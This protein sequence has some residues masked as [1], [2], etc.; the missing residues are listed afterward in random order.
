MEDILFLILQFLV[1]LIFEFICNLPW[2]FF[3]Y[4]TD[5]QKFSYWE[6]GWIT[7]GLGGVAGVVSLYFLPNAFVHVPFWRT[8]NAGLCPLSTGLISYEIA[9]WNKARGKDVVPLRH[10]LFSFLFTLAFAT[11]RFAHSQH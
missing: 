8:V 7:L 5:P 1:E 2:D 6:Y 9:R 10:F 3:T 11:V 4:R